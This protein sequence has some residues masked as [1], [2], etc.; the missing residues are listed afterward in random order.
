MVVLFADRFYSPGAVAVFV[1]GVYLS[2]CF[3][4]NKANK[5]KKKHKENHTF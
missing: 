5:Q 2:Y 1:K 3:E 4:Q